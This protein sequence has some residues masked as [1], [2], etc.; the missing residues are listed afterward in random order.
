MIPKKNF[1]QHPKFDLLSQQQLSLSCGSAI[2]PT[3]RLHYSPCN[4][5]KASEKAI[6]STV[7]FLQVRPPQSLLKNTKLDFKPLPPLEDTSFLLI[8]NPHQ[9][10]HH[11]TPSGPPPPTLALTMILLAPRI[12]PLL[13]SE[14][15][16]YDSLNTMSSSSTQHI[17]LY[18]LKL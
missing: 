7:P 18:P 6:H 2:H 5:V 12:L 14:T 8:S 17:H 16:K 3:L 13:T 10:S 11:P 1:R 9:E 4:L 15:P